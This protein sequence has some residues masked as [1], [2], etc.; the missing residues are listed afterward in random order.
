MTKNRLAGMIGLAMKSGN[1]ASGELAATESIK[2]GRAAL[3]IIAK[4]ASENTRDRFISL[5]R[6][7]RVEPYSF[8]TREELGTLIGK[9]ERSVLVITDH[10]FADVINKLFKESEA[11]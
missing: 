8:G 7:R 5:C 6:S 1:V 9:N 4:D 2:A 11:E 10:G 3:V